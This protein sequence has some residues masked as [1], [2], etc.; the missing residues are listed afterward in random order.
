VNDKNPAPAKETDTTEQ[1]DAEQ[2]AQDEA[3]TVDK[4]SSSSTQSSDDDENLLEMNDKDPVPA[5][6]A[7]SKDHEPDSK[8]SALA[9]VVKFDNTAQRPAKRRRVQKKDGE[10]VGYQGFLRP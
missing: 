2:S 1:T 7:S 6:D 9:Q 10:V 3:V 8:L 4:K 5:K